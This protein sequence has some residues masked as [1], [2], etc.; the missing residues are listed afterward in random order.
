MPAVLDRLLPKTDPLLTLGNFASDMSLPP[1]K[2]REQ[3]SQW[4]V[5]FLL[6]A[7]RRGGAGFR[8]LVI[9]EAAALLTTAGELVEPLANAARTLRSFN[10]GIVHAAQDFENALPKSLVETL[11]L[12]SSWWA[13]FQ[14]RRDG[15]WIA[16]YA[17]DVAEGAKGRAA[18][19]EQVRALPCLDFYFYAKRGHALRARSLDVIA[20]EERTGK[21]KE[22]LREIFRTKIA[23]HSQIPSAVA[24]AAIE[25]WEAEVVDPPATPTPS[26]RPKRK[27]SKGIADFLSDMEDG[28]A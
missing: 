23:V 25:K 17:I 1:S 26:A 14:S 24:E 12:N 9:E 22:E 19:V 16:P 10:T 21:S 20:P 11:T 5:D 4:I 28:D 7:P 13:M 18:F 2:A 3:A 15:E 6:E 27:T 8:R